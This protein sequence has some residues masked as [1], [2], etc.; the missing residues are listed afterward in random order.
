MICKTCGLASAV[1]EGYCGRCLEDMAERGEP[2]TCSRCAELEA[3]AKKLLALDAWLDKHKSIP[4][5]MGIV[6]EIRDAVSAT[7][8]E[9][10]G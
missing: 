8:D 4:G 3:A 2:V 7:A 1:F 10:G 5:Y 6:R 9:G